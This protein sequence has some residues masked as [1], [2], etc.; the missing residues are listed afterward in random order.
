MIKKDSMKSFTIQKNDAGQRLDKFITKAVPRLPKSL[1]YKYIRLKRIKLNGKRCGISDKL[2]E[3]DVLAMYIGD[4]FFAAASESDFLSVSANIEVVYEDDNILLVN[5]PCGLVVH[6]DN[7]GAMDTLM[8]RI[9]KYLYQKGEYLPENEASFA[10]SLCNRLDRN[11]QGIVICAKTAESL[12]I[13]NQ[14]VK[15]RWIEKK[16]L[17]V[18]MGE[19]RPETATLEGYLI[20]NSSDNI[21]RIYNKEVRG[22]KKILTGYK[23]LASKAG[24]S[25]CE[26]N[27][28][29]GRTHQIRAHMAHIGCPLLGDGKYGINDLNRQYNVKTQALCAYKLKFLDDK[30]FGELNYLRG[31]EFEIKD[32]WFKKYFPS[33]GKRD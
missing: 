14:A 5:K 15:E 19:P 28:I 26:I 17:C 29:T 10:P 8:N 1:M 21:V 27:L 11:T 33:G 9:K 13:L 2:S 6:E 7:V 24:L 16:Y 20:K 25:L 22:S 23:V 3:G 4:E 18:V 30:D 31:R 12:R 32:I